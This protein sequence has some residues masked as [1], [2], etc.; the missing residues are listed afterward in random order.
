MSSVF[1]G[2][3]LL[4]QCLQ[5]VMPDATVVET[6]LPLTPELKLWLLSPDF[7]HQPYSMEES[8]RIMDNPPYW[9]F[10]WASGQVLAHYILTNPQIV[11]GKQVVDFGC[12]SGVVA[13]AAA[14]AGAAGVTACDI[15][16]DARSAT[17]ANATLNGTEVMICNH[18]DEVSLGKDLLVAA[19]VLYDLENR[20]LLKRF[21]ELASEV[22]VADSRAKTVEPDY[23]RQ[24][25]EERATTLPDYGE[26]DEFK[27]VKIYRAGANPVS[28][29]SA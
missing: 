2:E 1:N 13:V 20:P 26:F 23:Y 19:D 7:H 4:N 25:G 14:L 28:A 24:V 22:I 27:Q 21:A 10:C 9:A 8:A 29:C 5:S 18:L 17:Q 3:G 12:G 11:A 15:D 16:P 6:A